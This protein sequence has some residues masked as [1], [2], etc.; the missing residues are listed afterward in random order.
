[1]AMISWVFLM[2]PF[3]FE[4]VSRARFVRHPLGLLVLVIGLVSWV[5][6]ILRLSLVVVI[7]VRPYTWLFVPVRVSITILVVI[8]ISMDLI[9]VL[10]I[11]IS[12]RIPVLSRTIWRRALPVSLLIVRCFWVSMILIGIHLLNLLFLFFAL[13]DGLI[14]FLMGYLIY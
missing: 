14:Y 11:A 2:S 13:I 6:R 4:A 7:H 3:S 1:M 8:W 10:I 9:G 5:M 12:T